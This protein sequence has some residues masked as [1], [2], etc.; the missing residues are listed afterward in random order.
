MILLPPEGAPTVP[1]KISLVTQTAGI[2]R[3]NIQA[4]FWAGELPGEHD[5][6]AQLQ[7]SRVTL[8]QA[9]KEL[10]QEGWLCSRQG[11]RHGIARRSRRAAGANRR[12]VLLTESPLH[13]LQP[14]T[15]YWMD[16]LREHLNEAGYR[17]EIHTRGAAFGANGENAL[18]QMQSLY[19]PAGWV[20]YRSNDR[21]QHWFSA[22]ALPCV[23]AGSRHAGI[24]LPSVDVDYRAACRHAA[25]Q[26]IL[27]KHKHIV[28]LNPASGAAGDLESEE[29][30]LAGAKGARNGDV[31]ALVVH[32]DG[33]VR[34]ICTKVDL[35]LARP[36]RPTAFLV[37]RPAFVLT[38][39]S[40]LLSRKLELPRD[41]ALISRDNES[42][43]E[44][45]VPTIACYSSKPPLL[46]R[47]ISRKVLAVVRG[48]ALSSIDTRIMP[49][50]VPGQ[51]LG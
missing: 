14:F 17:L 24:R 29:G 4:G 18:A 10:R 20:L 12:V 28:F 43:L 36:H 11:K 6:C 33:T 44:S 51:T 15:I 13:L 46:A 31:E 40:H 25:G 23:I 48:E 5:L 34:G 41:V 1:Q 30:F 42:F 9:L 50:F 32:H 21:M 16:C 38:V 22:Q 27:R 3:N 39:L 19:H 7:V 35:L 26:F 49:V 8:R 2:L 37:S 45:M 47:K